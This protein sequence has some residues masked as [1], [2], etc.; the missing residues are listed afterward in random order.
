MKGTAFVLVRSVLANPDDRETFN[1]WYQT[2]HYPLIFSKVPR[3]RKLGDSGVEL[4]RR[5]IMR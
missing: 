3:S 1:H 4:S 5:S 2:D